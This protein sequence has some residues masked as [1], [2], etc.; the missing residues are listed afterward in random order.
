MQS[1]NQLTKPEILAGCKQATNGFINQGFR[2]AAIHPY[3]DLEGNPTY[4]RVRLENNIDEKKIF[5]VRFNDEKFELKEP[6]FTGKK[7]LYKQH[8]FMDADVIIFVE[9]EKCADALIKLG[10]YA[11]TSGGSTSHDK[12]DFEP[13]RGEIV[14]IWPDNDEAGFKHA[15]A[16]KEIL[17]ALN[18]T[19]FMVDVH[20]LGLPEKGDVVDWLALHPQATKDDLKRLPTL[21]DAVIEQGD[22]A[23]II[24][25]ATGQ[26]TA[27]VINGSA[28][29]QN[30]KPKATVTL[31]RASEVTVKP[32]TWI[33]DKWLPQGKLT[34]LG[35]A[36]G[37]GKTTLAL[38]LASAITTGGMFP[39]KSRFHGQGNI[40]IWSSE[41]DP[42]DVLVPRM[43]AMQA[44]LSR[45]YFISAMGEGEERRA[46]DPATDIKALGEEAQ[47]IIGGVSLLIIDPIV[48]AV[49]KDMN[50][51]NDVRRSLQPIV[52]FATQYQCAVIGISHLGKGTQ[53]KE[54]TERLLG[55]QAFT[56]FA[57]MVWLTAS[58]KETG[59]RVLVRSKSNI[60]ALDGG[61]S[62]AIE[63]TEIGQGITTSQV[64]WKEEVEGYA[65]EILQEYETPNDGEDK[66]SKAARAEQFLS[67]LLGQGN[68][69]EKE[70]E[71]AYKEAGF[72]RSTITRAKRKIGARSIKLG[73]EKGWIWSLPNDTQNVEGAQNI[74]NM[75]TQKSEYL[76]KKMSTFIENTALDDGQNPSKTSHFSDADHLAGE[77]LGEAF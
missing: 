24:A 37:T 12:A 52:D 63:Q 76:H 65:A 4:W 33:W 59:D 30:G 29:L 18:C 13:L 53:G 14:L 28:A 71:Q 67:E 48:S 27:I 5:P 22:P 34:I 72:S 64:V 41:D 1:I 35:G 19:V 51:A 40:L 62:Y 36:G 39:D 10:L 11:T 44:N 45:V 61:F 57:R 42:D 49:A 26:T 32:I 50:Q 43:M 54:P 46:F 2:L 55:S 75:L 16:V 15:K 69:P 58:N 73:M 17:L 9:G 20:A 74:P 68:M 47:K 21:Q 8:T 7:P 56:A 31:T 23:P 3:T 77:N 6:I 70:V 38:G 25:E 66:N 60:S